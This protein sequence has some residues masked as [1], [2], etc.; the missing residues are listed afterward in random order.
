LTYGAGVQAFETKV[1]ETDH[2]GLVHLHKIF[3]KQKFLLLFGTAFDKLIPEAY[4]GSYSIGLRIA[5]AFH[6]V[7]LAFLI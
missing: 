7:S 4:A 6:I 3:T 2:L 5:Q 1:L